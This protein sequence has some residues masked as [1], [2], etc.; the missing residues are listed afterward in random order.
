MVSYSWEDQRRDIQRSINAFFRRKIDIAPRAMASLQVGATPDIDDDTGE[1]FGVFEYSILNSLLKSSPG[2]YNLLFNSGVNLESLEFPITT[3]Q[4]APL[5]RGTLDWIFKGV[6]AAT[7][8]STAVN[9]LKRGLLEETDILVSSLEASFAGSEPNEFGGVLLKAAGI[10]EPSRVRG[11]ST[12]IDSQWEQCDKYLKKLLLHVKQLSI[13]DP[14]HAQIQFVLYEDHERRIRLRP[15]GTTGISLLD[16]SPPVEEGAEYIYRGG[17]F[18]PISTLYPEFSNNLLELFE[19]LLN[20]N[21]SSEADFQR[22]F[23][24]YPFL[25]TGLDFKRA[26]PQPILYMDEGKKLI[27]DFF[28]EKLD[29]GWDAILDIKRPYDEMVSRRPNRIYFKQH[30]HNAISQLRYYREWFDSPLNRKSFEESYGIRTF[31]P[32]MIIV[33]GRSHHFRNDIERIRLMEGLPSRLD[34]WTYDDLYNRAKRYLSM[35]K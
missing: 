28:L 17:I 35:V 20:S 33:I 10:K 19:N 5:A 30:I 22:F 8:V 3:N 12:R 21:N 7:K 6:E 4:P 34:L 14:S 32:K 9:I 27:P 2:C 16:I 23:E 25:V 31:R 1:S 18:Q 24:K 26:H 13:A 29:S 11:Y 15:F